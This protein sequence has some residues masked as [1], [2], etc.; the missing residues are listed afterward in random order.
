LRRALWVDMNFLLSCRYCGYEWNKMGYGHIS[1]DESC[2]KCNDKNIDVRDLSKT[3][4]DYY[5]GSPSFQDT[6]EEI[7]D[8]E[9]GMSDFPFWMTSGGD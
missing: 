9:T 1:E 6:T 2:L 5:A 7:K 4:V 8:N 3:K